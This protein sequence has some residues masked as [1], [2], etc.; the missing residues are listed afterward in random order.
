MYTPVF[1]E[2]LF[3]S[4]LTVEGLTPIRRAIIRS[5][6]FSLSPFLITYL[7]DE[8]SCLYINRNIWDSVKVT[9]FEET[10]VS[11]FHLGGSKR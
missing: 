4:R 7:C 11:S 6:T 10:S 8:V 9:H 2:F 5:G 3:I 1:E